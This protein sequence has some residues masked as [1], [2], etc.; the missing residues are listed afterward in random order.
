MDVSAHPVGGGKREC[1]LVKVGV[2]IINLPI[3]DVSQATLIA[4]KRSRKSAFQ[5]SVFSLHYA[6]LFLP[7][8]INSYTSAS[9]YR[10]V[11]RFAAG[12]V[13]CR[14]RTLKHEN[15]EKG[16]KPRNTGHPFRAFRFFVSFVI[17]TPLH[18]RN[19]LPRQP[20][21][22]IHQRVQLPLPLRYL[23][24]LALGIQQLAHQCLDSGALSGARHL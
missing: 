2:G 1:F 12:R 23:G 14:R 10:S 18:N 6:N 7:Q 20:I 11:P 21:Q 9:T 13:P 22:L 4:H 8:L 15:H 17:Q 16:R 24:P 19:L 3:I 5:G